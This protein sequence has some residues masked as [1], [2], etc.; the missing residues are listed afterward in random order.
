MKLGQY[1]K[2]LEDLDQNKTVSM[3]LGNPHC[4]R[5]SYD[6]VSFEP[7]GPV[8]VSIMLSDAKSALDGVYQGWKGGEFTFD[9]NTKVHVDYEG[10][11]TDNTQLFNVL[12]EYMFKD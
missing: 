7:V 10:Q 6:E 5:G 3:G 11:F 1:I 2:I 4:W 12:F 9:E 8:K